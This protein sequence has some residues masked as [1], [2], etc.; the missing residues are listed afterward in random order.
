MDIP[1]RSVLMSSAKTSKIGGNPP[2]SKRLEKLG[3]TNLL[4]RL[5]FGGITG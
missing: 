3:C 1:L 2:P 5:L 4:E